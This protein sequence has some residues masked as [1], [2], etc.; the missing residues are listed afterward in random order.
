M[1]GDDHH[2]HC[3]PW[4]AGHLESEAAG[5]EGSPGETGGGFGSL[6]EQRHL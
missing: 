3:L 1:E 4:G 6:W 5:L 2:S